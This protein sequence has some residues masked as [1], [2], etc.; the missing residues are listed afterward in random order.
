MYSKIFILMSTGNTVFSFKEICLLWNERDFNKAAVTIHNLVKKGELINLRKGVYS[1][2]ENFEVEEVPSK[3]YKPSYVSLE[4]ILYK[5]NIIFQNYFSVFSVS[6]LS[7]EIEIKNRKYIFRKI[8]N[9]ILLNPLGIEKGRYSYATP[10]RAILDTL[11]LN[12]EYYFDNLNSINWELLLDLSSIY[13][14]KNLTKRIQKLFK[15]YK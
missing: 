9:S 6:Y 11:Y 3:I 2:K 4:T 14:N 12:K 13:E 5:E 7:R 8:N 15:S 1:I 10:E